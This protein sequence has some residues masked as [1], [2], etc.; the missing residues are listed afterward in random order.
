MNEEAQFSQALRRV[1][2]KLLLGDSAPAAGRL[3]SRPALGTE[4]GADVRVRVAVWPR[5][6]SGM[7]K[8]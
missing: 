2:I 3:V 4:T 6:R 5:R 7:S 1:R 8:N